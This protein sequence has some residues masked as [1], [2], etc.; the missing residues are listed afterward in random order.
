L[1]EDELGVVHYDVLYPPSDKSPTGASGSSGFDCDTIFV[2]DLEDNVV[3]DSLLD[4]DGF[5]SFSN[6]MVKEDY[7]R[8]QCLTSNCG[9]LGGECFILKDRNSPYNTENVIPGEEDF[10]WR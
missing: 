9:L 3:Y 1:A 8:A 7:F 5:W 10:I 4:S 6:S 2:I